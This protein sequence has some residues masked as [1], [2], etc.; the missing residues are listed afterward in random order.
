MFR[1]KCFE[2]ILT[3]LGYYIKLSD[4]IWDISKQDLARKTTG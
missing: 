3:L 4:N 2:N 1:E